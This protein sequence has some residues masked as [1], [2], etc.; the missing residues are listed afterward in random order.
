MLDFNALLKK[1]EAEC[2]ASL[3]QT[4][5]PMPHAN[6][7]IPN[8]NRI[9]AFLEDREYD[10]VPFKLEGPANMA[11]VQKILRKEQSDEYMHRDDNTK[12][13]NIIKETDNPHPYDAYYQR[14]RQDEQSD[15]QTQG[16]YG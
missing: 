14:K 11:A 15:R 16:N 9:K 8:V 1:K 2:R 3:N 7:N 10:G 12:T 5:A 6:L 13:F 4:P